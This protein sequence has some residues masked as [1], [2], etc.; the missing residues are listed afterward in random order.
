MKRLLELFEGPEAPG[1]WTPPPVTAALHALLP[2]RAFDESSELYINASSAG[3]IVELPP[4]AGIDAE[5]LGALAGTLADAAPER[6]TVQVIHWAS[7]R[8]GAA[9]RAWAEP[10]SDAGGALAKM[11]RERRDLLAP[12]GWR[13]LHAGGPPFT[14]SDYRVLFTAC[15]AGP[16]SPAAETGLG[17]FRR[18]LEGT[19]AS[20][21]AQTRRLEPDALLSVAAELAAPDIAGYRDGGAERPPRRWSP[22]DPLHEQGHHLVGRMHGD[23]HDILGQRDLAGLDIPVPDLA[24]H[25]AVGVEHAVPGQRLHGPEAASAGDHGVA[26]GS[27][28]CRLIG[29][30]D[31]ILQQ[32]E[33]GDRGLEL[34]VGPGIG[35]R[36]A[37]ILGGERKPAQRDLPDARFGPGGD[38][39][40]RSLL[41]CGSGA[42]GTASSGLQA[43][44]RPGPAS[45][46]RRRFRSEVMS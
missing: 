30:D 13:R 11:G 5:T 1:P 21:G 40:H 19:L 46:F 37:D 26:V 9:S 4:F 35:R 12:G 42:P 10:R 44:I 7:P 34:G 28:L 20:A 32:A 33:G 29:A 22:R 2:W 14:L 31:Q 6:C 16:P 25:G 17:A 15:L 8:F 27:V 39:V 43:P 18:A 41:D 38:G 45:G 23:A 36:L 3:F 24:G